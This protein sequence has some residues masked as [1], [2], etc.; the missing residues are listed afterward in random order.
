MVDKDND[1]NDDDKMNNKI[2]TKTEDEYY[3]F[4]ENIELFVMMRRTFLL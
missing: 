3:L 2:M 4:G 1:N